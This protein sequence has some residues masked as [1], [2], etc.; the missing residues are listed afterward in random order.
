MYLCEDRMRAVE[1][2]IKYGH[3]TAGVIR[4]LGYP[5]SR[6]ALAARVDELAPGQQ[7]RGEDGRQ[8][9]AFLRGQGR[10]GGS[11]GDEGQVG[12]RGRL[13][14]RPRTRGPLLAEVRPAW[15][16]GALHYVEKRRENQGHG[17]PG[18]AHRRARGT[19]RGTRAA[20][21]DARGEGR[22]PGIKPG[23]RPELADE[24]GED[25]AGRL[26]STLI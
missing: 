21:G 13:R 12:C 8:L 26:E 17:R 23:R 25:A 9:R 22:A 3:S 4:E 24:Q 11:L 16:E 1:L 19:G 15:K 5:R 14:T 20:Q 7:A 18:G 2:Y 6:A 10:R